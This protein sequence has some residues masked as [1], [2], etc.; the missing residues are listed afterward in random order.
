MSSLT[1]RQTHALVGLVQQRAMQ[2]D[3]LA[4]FLGTGRNHAYET[5][6]ALREA[7]M[8]HPPQKIGAGSSWIVPTRRAVTRHYGR[9][10]S[11]WTPSRLWSI[12]GRAAARARIGLGAT[13]WA[14][15]ESERELRYNS[16]FPGAY[17]LDGIMR[18][19]NGD[20]LAVRVL[21]RSDA[22]VAD[23]V[24]TLTRATDRA[25]HEQ[26]TALLVVHSHPTGVAMVRTALASASLPVALGVTATSL[27]ALFRDQQATL[28]HNGAGHRLALVG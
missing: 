3:V 24:H 16:A 21:T 27:E 5:A 7:G 19:T 25:A 13:G 12:R 26:C 11:D 8:V 22:T 23:L 17:P 14:D 1:R 2:V 6:A 9:P 4:E 28:R 18:R 15:W 20:D 10:C